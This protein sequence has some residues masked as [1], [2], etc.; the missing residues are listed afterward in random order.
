MI[1]GGLLSVPTFVELHTEMWLQCSGERK[2]E[3]DKGGREGEG[4]RRRVKHG[5]CNHGRGWAFSEDSALSKTVCDSEAIRT[6]GH[7]GRRG[8]RSARSKKLRKLFG[9]KIG[10]TW[11]TGMCPGRGRALQPRPSGTDVPMPRLRKPHNPTP[12]A[13]N[14]RLPLKDLTS[15]DMPMPCIRRYVELFLLN[16][17]GGVASRGGR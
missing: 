15:P 11:A 12:H 5:K 8:C 4:E 14:P 3:G 2:R 1:F 10:I 7:L 6:A 17:G 16:E 13:P 9:R